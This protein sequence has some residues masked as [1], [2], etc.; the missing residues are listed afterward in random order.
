MSQAGLATRSGR[1]QFDGGDDA[2]G[3]GNEERD[4]GGQA[5]GTDQACFHGGGGVGICAGGHGMDSVAGV[6][7]TGYAIA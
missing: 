7:G 6:T 4:D 3:D 5:V 2:E 1:D